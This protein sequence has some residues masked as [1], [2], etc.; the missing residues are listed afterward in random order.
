[1]ENNAR[2]HIAR[3]AETAIANQQW[4]RL[5][6]IGNRFERAGCYRDYWLALT[7]ASEATTRY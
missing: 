3:Q 4:S 6:F 7:Q 5:R 1:M 2:Q